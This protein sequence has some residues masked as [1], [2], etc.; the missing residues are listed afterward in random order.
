[1]RRPALATFAPMVLALAC[2]CTDATGTERGGEALTGS[3]Q[4]NCDPTWTSLYAN[5]FGPLGQASCS[6]STQST[7]HGDPSQSGAQTSGFVCGSSKD[8]CWQGMTAGVALDAGGLFC[9]IVCLGTCP[10]N[11]QACPTDPTQQTLWTSIHGTGG[12]G[13]HNMPCGD[14]TICHAANATY[15]FTDTDLACISQWVQQGAQND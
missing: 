11:S 5:Y 14:P 1:M 4:I 10:Q 13:L 8:A 7:C 2:G 9:P 6:P 3:S 15:T 12:T